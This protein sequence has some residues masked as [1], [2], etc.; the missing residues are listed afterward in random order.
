[1]LKEPRQFYLK[2][3]PHIVQ[4]LDPTKPGSTST[5]KNYKD[6]LRSMK[7]DRLFTKETVIVRS[8]AE[9]ENEEQN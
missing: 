8:N 5:H 1:M 6:R 4:A 3:A 2:R 9:E 7:G